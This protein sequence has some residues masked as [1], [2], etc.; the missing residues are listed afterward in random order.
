MSTAVSEIDKSINLAESIL[1]ALPDEIMSVGHNF[2]Y[3]SRQARP[4]RA[5]TEADEANEQVIF[6]D[7]GQARSV[8]LKLPPPDARAGTFPQHNTPGAFRKDFETIS[9]LRLTDYEGLHTVE[10]LEK[11]GFKLQRAI[12]TRK[13]IDRVAHQ[14][15]NLS[16]RCFR[17]MMCLFDDSKRD[18]EVWIKI[19][20]DH[21]QWAVHEGK[22]VPV[23]IDI[24][25][26][27]INPRL[28]LIQF[29]QTVQ[30]DQDLNI[31]DLRHVVFEVGLPLVA[32]QSCFDK[33][34]NLRN[35]A[36]VGVTGSKENSFENSL[37]GLD[38]GTV[39][40]TSS[41]FKDGKT[42]SGAALL[43]HS[44]EVVLLAD[45]DRRM[46]EF[47]ARNLGAE[48]INPKTLAWTGRYAASAAKAEADDKYVVRTEYKQAVRSQVYQ[49]VDGACI[50]GP[51]PIFNPLRLI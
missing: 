17:D 16:P 51:E 38:V 33:F 50:P 21:D 18:F 27:Y 23:A 12:L 45:G 46:A 10:C 48:G 6:T 9:S 22:R 39:I 49:I 47:S 30:Y 28:D 5:R 20:Q 19:P 2:N 25:I 36:H 8:E 32:N 31:I 24:D 34:G 43:R 37:E 14:F 15:A 44:G 13:H 7:F 35:I 42:V 26:A 29:I 3:F 1:E 40:W 41:D 11:A 4:N